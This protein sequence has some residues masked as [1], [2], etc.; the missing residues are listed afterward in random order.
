[1][2]RKN[3]RMWL[4]LV[5]PIVL[6]SL[7]IG[8]LLLYS[9]QAEKR[10]RELTYMILEA[11]GSEQS[12]LLNTKL[13]GETAILGALAGVV[14]S[15]ETPDDGS[16][17]TH[18]HAAAVASDFSQFCIV[19]REGNGFTSE[20]EDVYLG[21]RPYFQEAL[22]GRTAVAHVTD[23]R[24][25]TET[26]A[27]V[28]AVPVLRGGAAD[29]AV[30][31]LLSEDGLKELL[32]TKSFSG[33]VSFLCDSAG[34]IVVGDATV[35]GI[36]KYGSLAD[37]FAHAEFD[38]GFSGPRAADDLKNGSEGFASYRIDG[39]HWYLAYV[40]LEKND[41]MI[42][43]AIPGG[44]VDSTLRAEQ[45]DGFL[46]IGAAM[47]SALLLILYVISLYARANRRAAREKEQL[48]IAVEEYRISAQ[49]SGA[50]ILRYDLE[51]N[52]LMPNESA[53]TQFRLPLEATN[54]DY[55]WALDALVAE[56]S[57]ADYEAFWDAIQAGEPV[58]CA[59]LQMKNA[60]GELRWY[61]F[62]F[63]AIK[64]S[65]GKS[66][67][68]VIT[69]RDITNQREKLMEYERWRAMVSALIGRSAA[70]V[71]I[72]LSTGGVERVEGEF[73][74]D[75]TDGASSAEEL[76]HA[77]E[78]SHVE[79][80]DR[81]KFRSFLSL[82]RLKSL[83]FRGVLK[84]ESEVHLVREDGTAR[85]CSVSVQMSQEP[86]TDEAK[87]IIAVTDLGDSS[88]DLERLSD[89]ALKDG[90]SG[91]L[92][93]TAARA[94]IE[95]ALRFG[96]GEDVAL[97]M[98]DFDNFKSVNDTMG[99][100]QGD[101]ALVRFGEILRGVFRSTDVIA[102]IGGDEFFVFLEDASAPGLVESKAAAL[103]EA[104]RFSYS[105]GKQSVPVSTSVGVV[106][107]RRGETDYESLYSEADAA[108]YEA[109]NAGKN[110]FR[111]RRMERRAV[112]EAPLAQGEQRAVELYSLLKY[113]DGGVA[114]I[115]V[116]QTIDLLFLS[117]GGLNAGQD[118]YCAEKDVHPD[119]RDALLAQMHACAEKGVA[120]E[121]VYRNRQKDGTYGWRHMNAAR[122][123]YAASENP[124]IIA[125][126]TDITAIKHSAARMESM[127]AAPPIGVAI[128]RFGERVEVT[129][130][131][132]ALLQIFQL[133]YEQFHLIARDCAALFTKDELRIIR[134]AVRR[135]EDGHAPLEFSFYSR[136]RDGVSTRIIRARGA[137]IDAQN[138]VPAYLLLLAAETAE[139]LSAPID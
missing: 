74:P 99:H 127:L 112:N 122:I 134:Q 30:V 139:G 8:M 12:D 39:E 72:N 15:S 64:N 20:G 4:T 22:S 121:A 46:L 71:E 123:P 44:I 17:R 82:E 114:L 131:N 1:M 135:A 91:L 41:W 105:D 51:A 128:L 13:N 86:D 116:G 129:F 68:A 48:S 55:A 19:D 76:L 133:S 130:F 32:L 52:M 100:R 50:M 62:A 101:Q 73:G 97:F 117:E 14:A 136:G 94:A 77:F 102:R 93:R 57:R 38:A 36:S 69:V 24:V 33:S 9:A 34:R 85:L 89:L 106:L 78:F 58:G 42:C 126:I 27:F 53:N 60:S 81:E 67:Q 21:D 110:C 25:G 95:E 109:K 10:T 2:I 29:G 137:K 54:F 108:L 111:I 11:A 5:V 70:Y 47:T 61:A 107:A 75:E 79:A 37:V 103:C 83:L 104:L 63:T 31:G 132:D 16:L 92:N 120:F 23:A 49:Q 115:S 45:A 84:D 40:P 90:L 96:T 87:A 18:M 125:V 80:A 118:Q 98:L 26:S 7:T 28:L 56:T 3:A 88:R 113:V 43:T 66:I 59:E 35:F 6:V 138:G 65:A 124:V 119:D